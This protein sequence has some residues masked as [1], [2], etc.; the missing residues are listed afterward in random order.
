MHN[1][2]FL[3]NTINIIYAKAV[4][5]DCSCGGVV[6]PG[7]CCLLTSFLPKAVF[8]TVT[9]GGTGGYVQRVTPLDEYS[10]PSWLS[11]L[12]ALLGFFLREPHPVLGIWNLFTRQYGIQRFL[13]DGRIP[14]GFVGECPEI[15]CWNRHGAS[16]PSRRL[17]HIA[18]HPPSP[19]SL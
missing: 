3:K 12:K 5:G 7:V 4:L 11:F 18:T 8:G 19:P 6:P 16:G 15:P 1:C 14:Q 17:H 10:N 13:L 9:G 2:I